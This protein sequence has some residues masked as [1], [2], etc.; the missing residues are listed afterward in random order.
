[1]GD[2]RFGWSILS[3]F[4]QSIKF[5]RNLVNKNVS[6]NSLEIEISKLL[7]DPAYKINLAAQL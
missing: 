4:H 2:S 1:M 5:L 7:N 6:Q 3:I